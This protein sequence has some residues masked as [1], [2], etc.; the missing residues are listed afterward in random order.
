MFGNI[1]YQTIFFCKIKYVNS[2]IF[3]WL[4]KFRNYKI[5]KTYIYI[6]I[7]ICYM[8][9]EC[10]TKKKYLEKKLFI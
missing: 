10:N 5:L 7:F 2:C 9:L 8:P 4:K 3:I 6:Y 1:K